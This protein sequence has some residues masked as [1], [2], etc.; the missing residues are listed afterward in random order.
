MSTLP[1]IITESP[2]IS[3][4]LNEK[5]VVFND[6][7]NININDTNL[8]KIVE[9]LKKLENDKQITKQDL[10]NF[11]I[12]YKDTIRREKI[13]KIVNDIELGV[14][15][16]FAI[17]KLKTILNLNNNA[18]IDLQNNNSNNNNNEN[19]RKIE[20]ISLNQYKL[21]NNQI[22]NENN[23]SYALL[24]VINNSKL[25][26]TTEN[27]EN[28]NEIENN[29]KILESNNNSGPKMTKIINNI[30]ISSENSDINYILTKILQRKKEF[31][32]EYQLSKVGSRK[33]AVIV[34]HGSYNPLTRMNMRN[35]FIAKQE[36]ESRY[37]YVI[38]GSILSPIHGVT[39][40]EKYSNNSNDV[41]P[42]NHRLA[43]AQLMVK[44]SKWLNI[45]SWEITRKKPMNYIA[46]LDH[47]AT[48]LKSEINDIDIQII[49][50][51]PA[52]N[53]IKLTVDLSILKLKSYIVCTLCR[54]PE[55]NNFRVNL[56]SKWNNMIYVIEDNE[57][58][59]NNVLINSQI[60]RE[61]IKLNQSIDYLV[62]DFVNSYIISHKLGAK[63]SYISFL[64]V[65]YI[66]SVELS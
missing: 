63:V 14:N 59:N 45:D 27:I 50:L 66:L 15:K 53:V 26:K 8:S 37:G 29:D 30:P 20:D 44:D 55:S 22:Y 33:F 58:L 34:G 24:P 1:S 10:I 47:I 61:N 16:R 42:S 48:I 11:K 13:I 56:G 23:P 7:N 38:L 54:A 62:G 18:N 19:Q 43:I 28:I 41:M 35:Y 5:K 65:I 25:S 2:P 21:N 32:M 17:R 6:N 46:Y 31:F 49:Y 60:I 9:I 57:V 40:R 4:L 64:S 36:L 3:P 39:L 51:S 12:V 52:D